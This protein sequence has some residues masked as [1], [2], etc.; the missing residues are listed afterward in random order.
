MMTAL[1]LSRRSEGLAQALYLLHFHLSLG[2]LTQA[3]DFK[4]SQHTDDPQIY[5][6]ILGSSSG[7]QTHLR[8]S[9]PFNISFPA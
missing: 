4:Y 3:H 1:L 5:I 8:F 9:C 7:L 6:S 2:G